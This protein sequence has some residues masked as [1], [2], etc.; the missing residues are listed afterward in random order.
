[1]L[2]DP[3]VL[4]DQPLR[5][6]ATLGII[7]VGKS[8]AAF[9]IVLVFRYPLNTA[10][11]VS[12]SLAQIGE[13]SFILAALGVSLRLLPVE[14]Q[15]LILA[16]AFISITLN[17]LVFKIIEPAQAWIRARSSW[18]VCWNDRTILWLNCATTVA[19]SYVTSHVVL[20]G[21]PCRSL[22]RRSA[23]KKGRRLLWRS[24]TGK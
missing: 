20:V 11:T 3:N 15:S 23:G 19:S 8:L 4:I 17:P 18:P 13:F 7:I 22:Y 14:A 5:V 9:L 12:A 10:L 6:L 16:G 24:K 2:F 1:M 21:W